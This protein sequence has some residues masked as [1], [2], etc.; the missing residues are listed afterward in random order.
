MKKLFV[1]MCFSVITF[2][3]VMCAAADVRMQ[4]GFSFDWWSDNRDSDARQIS[5]PF[6]I[7]GRAGDFS[8]TLLTAY[9]DTRLSPSGRDAVSLGH[10]L[11]TKLSL[12]W[13]ITERL[14]VDILFGLDFNL[15]T[16][17]TNLSRDELDLVMDPDLLSINTFGEGFNINPTV[18][19]AREW[20]NW[21]AGLGF[22]YLWRGEYDYSADIGVTDYS[23][24]DIITLSGE[25]RYHFSQD[26]H[27]RFFA[28]HSWYGKDR[29]RGADYH[30][31]GD[32]TLVGLGAHYAPAERWSINATLRGVF[33]DRSKS[34]SASG[35]LDAEPH[36]IHGDELIADLAVQ[37]LLD[38]AT[39]IEPY[40]QARCRSSN[41]YHETS[42]N[43]IGG[44]SKYSLGIKATHAFTPHLEAGLDV[45]GFL[46]YDDDANYPYIQPERDFTGFSVALIL[47]GAF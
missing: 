40:F 22:G 2:H 37:R 5:V 25:V 26:L 21:V 6:R 30:Q 15:P 14:P 44:R 7:D 10:I 4:T 8:A 9:T 46:K 17:K 41:D 20:G 12:S 33:R 3:A 32:F 39:I 29:V 23:P 42:A 27:S 38:K 35:G 31:E 24:G 36:N 11:D 18:T 47:T 28:R 34:A 19:L 1:S 43:F 13:Q 16:G 45:R